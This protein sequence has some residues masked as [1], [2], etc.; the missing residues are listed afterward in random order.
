[1]DM[2]S[3]VNICHVS[4]ENESLGKLDRVSVPATRGTKVAISNIEERAIRTF[5]QIMNSDHNGE[6]DSTRMDPSYGLNSC[7]DAVGDTHHYRR[8]SME[9]LPNKPQLNDPIKNRMNSLFRSLGYLHYEK[10]SNRIPDYIGNSRRKLKKK[11]QNG[12]NN[13]R[14][15][16]MIQ[17]DSQDPPSQ[18]ALPIDVLHSPTVNPSIPFVSMVPNNDSS[19]SRD[20]NSMRTE[21]MWLLEM[22]NHSYNKVDLSENG[23]SS[24][25]FSLYGDDPV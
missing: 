3:Q 1:M 2:L 17:R 25:S 16:K 6:E 5:L 23:H 21:D 18:V 10:G 19:P 24:S 11:Q 8:R 7:G 12:G 20:D 9:S 14:L 15:D 13:K 22:E 4:Q